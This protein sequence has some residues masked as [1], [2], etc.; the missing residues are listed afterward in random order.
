[1]GYG[2]VILRKYIEH[3]WKQDI[4]KLRKKRNWRGSNGTSEMS[5]KVAPGQIKLDANLYSKCSVCDGLLK[6]RTD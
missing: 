3:K 4:N 2:T 5:K 1:M 6:Y